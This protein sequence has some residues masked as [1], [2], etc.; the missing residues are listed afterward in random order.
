METYLR[1]LSQFH[2]KYFNLQ[3]ELI[4]QA[5]P[6]AQNKMFMVLGIRNVWI[7]VK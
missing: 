4:E 3:W 2:E 7:E 5:N 6:K 1:Y